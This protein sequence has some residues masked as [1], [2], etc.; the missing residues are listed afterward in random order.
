M[1]FLTPFGILT[2]A[3]STLRA[4]ETGFLSTLNAF[5]EP[6]ARAGCGSPGITPTGLILLETT[7]RRSGHPHR[8]PVFALLVDG[9]LLVGTARGDRAHWVTN[10][11]ANPAVRYWL[12]GRAHQAQALVFTSDTWPAEAEGLP[13]L[14]R[15]IAAAIYGA[16]AAA[17]GAFALLP[18]AEATTTD[19]V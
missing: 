7:G 8:T 4:L 1:T 18:T 5:V 2:A 12:C 13:P 11:R 16:V 15:S 14:M 3:V 19:V 10:A 17:G 9:F 6:L